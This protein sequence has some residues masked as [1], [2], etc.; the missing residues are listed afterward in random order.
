MADKL[1]REKS[2]KK[3]ASPEELDRYIRISRPSIWLILSAIIVLLVGI[4]IWGI[5]GSL[6]TTTEVTGLVESGEMISVI[7][8]QEGSQVQPGMAVYLDDEKVGEVVDVSYNAE[9][10]L[11]AKLSLSNLADGSYTLT[12]MIEN[13]HPLYFILN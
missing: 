1:F 7:S 11:V 2:L 3:I 12:I 10:E 8:S 9:G 13:I 6:K 4:C 5:F